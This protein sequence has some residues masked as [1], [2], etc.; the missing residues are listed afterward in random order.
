MEIST[1]IPSK[2]LTYKI[3]LNALNQLQPLGN[4][5]KDDMFLQSIFPS[6]FWIFF[7]WFVLYKVVSLYCSL[8]ITT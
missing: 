7:F 4:V 2:Q 5:W 8:A 1:E 3:S 6:V